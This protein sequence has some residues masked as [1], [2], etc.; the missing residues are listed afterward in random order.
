M[1]IEKTY[2]PASPNLQLWQDFISSPGLFI[3]KRKLI[4]DGDAIFTMGSCFALEVRA[5]LERAGRE[6]FPDYKSVDFDS[7]CQIFDK[8]PER[9]LTPHYDTFVIR[10]E[11]ESAFGLWP[12]R[13]EGVWGVSE[14]PVNQLLGEDLVYQDPY[15]KMIYATSRPLLLELSNRI[16]DIMREGIERSKLIV[17]TLGLTEVWKHKTTSKY[18]CR[19]PSTGYGGG[20]G[21]AEFCQSTFSENYA[22]VKA[23]LDLLFERYPNKNVVLT[24]SP[25]PLAATYSKTD[26]ATANMESK[27]ILRAVAGQVC[28]EYENVHYFP[29]YEM[30]NV[31]PW[32]VFREDRRHILPEFADRVTGA[33]QQFYT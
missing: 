16:T 3:E 13:D 7:S 15:R 1:T 8:I 26:V 30:A 21:L 24:V 4:S 25:V 10:Q 11:F 2:T 12:D 27:S 23:T 31:M 33:F 9:T 18:L 29:S 19:P 22:N 5:A 20:A 6:V 28:R 17:I 14:S 32:P